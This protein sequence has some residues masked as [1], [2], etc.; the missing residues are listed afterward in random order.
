VKK[1]NIFQI[2]NEMPVP[3]SWNAGWGR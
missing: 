1:F 2:A 3:R